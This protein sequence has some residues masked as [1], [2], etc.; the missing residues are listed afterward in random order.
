[1]LRLWGVLNF[2][3]EILFP[4]D[5]YSSPRGYHKQESKESDQLDVMVSHALLVE[6]IFLAC[7]LHFVACLYLICC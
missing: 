2:D 5:S 4:H 3:V 6:V 1:M 7:P